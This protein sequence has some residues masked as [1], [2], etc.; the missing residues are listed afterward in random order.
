MAHRYST[1]PPMPKTS[2]KDTKIPEVSKQDILAAFVRGKEIRGVNRS[3]KTA[4]GTRGELLLFVLKKGEW[5]EACLLGS[6]TMQ[7]GGTKKYLILSPENLDVMSVR[8]LYGHF[9]HADILWKKG[10]LPMSEKDA[11][12]IA[13]GEGLFTQ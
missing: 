11:V 2:Q 10:M 5:K 9:N 6:V 8:V 7:I 12:S 13:T 3:M 1:G 4:K